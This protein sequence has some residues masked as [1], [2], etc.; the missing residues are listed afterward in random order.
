M[1]KTV[2]KILNNDPRI[3]TFIANTYVML[4]DFI[5]AVKYYKKAIKQAPRDNEIKLIYIEMA[6]AYINDKLA[7]KL[8]D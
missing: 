8:R 1:Y 5:Q 3:S 7:G 2:Q 6:S 4:G